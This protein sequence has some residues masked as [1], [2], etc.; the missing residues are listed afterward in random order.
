MEA[1]LRHILAAAAVPEPRMRAALVCERLRA[2]ESSAAVRSL[3]ALVAAAARK[4]A[5]AV[6]A[7]AALVPPDAAGGMLGAAFVDEAYGCALGEGRPLAAMWLRAALEAP[8]PA[9]RE[10]ARLV[11]RDFA[12][13]TL[14]GRRA[15]A[16]R[17][18]GEA[19]RKLLGDP[20]PGV[21]AN[22]VASPRATEAAVL[23]ICSKRPTVSAPLEAVLA[24]ARWGVRQRVRVALAKSP[25]LREGLA[26]TLLPLLDANDLTEVRDDATLPRARREIAA[27]LLG[28]VAR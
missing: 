8:E 20:D 11:H 13:M 18:R 3:D 21:I 24:S 6:L 25:H 23:A 10:A 15:L 26:E 27:L 17:A 14:G 19:L 22:I 7:Y 1:T 16:R 9:G 5:T 4:D 28:R 2:L 12:D